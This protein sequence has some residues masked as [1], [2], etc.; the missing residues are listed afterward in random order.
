MIRL[1]F[2]RKML[3]IKWR[4]DWNNKSKAGGREPG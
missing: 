4:T 3:P 1:A 2:Q